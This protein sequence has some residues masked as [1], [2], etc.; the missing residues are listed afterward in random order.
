[1]DWDIFRARCDGEF[2]ASDNG[3]KSFERMMK[4]EGFERV[5]FLDEEGPAVGQLIAW[6]SGDRDFEITVHICLLGL[7]AYGF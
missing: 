7:S 4:E 6:L 3:I 2:S 5:I 1:M